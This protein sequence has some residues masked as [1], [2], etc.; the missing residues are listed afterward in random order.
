MKITAI[1]QARSGP[2]TTL[3]MIQFLALVL[4]VAATLQQMQQF[5]GDLRL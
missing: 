1:A 2:N 5:R 3:F 4:A